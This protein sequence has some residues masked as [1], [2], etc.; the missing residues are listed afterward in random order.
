MP[1]R[2]PHTDLGVLTGTDTAEYYLEMQR[3]IGRF[4]LRR[5]R[6]MLAALGRSGRFL[7]IGTGPGYQTAVVAED[8]PDCEI[9][10]LEPSPDMVRIANAYVAEKGLGGRVRFVDGVA[11]DE[12]LVAGL[13]VFDLIY[14]TFSLHHWPDAPRALRN[15]YGALARA[16]PMLIFDFERRW[17]TYYLMPGTRG[18]RESIKA[19]YTREELAEMFRTA[20]I[21]AFA[22]ERCFPYMAAVVTK[23]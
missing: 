20:D 9:V 7:E 16:A 22:I 18:M 4:Y 6:K 14:S 3:R 12:V 13:G 11:E 21:R 8:H 23:K 10:G 2:I 17:L 5:F 19:A 1:K 15:L